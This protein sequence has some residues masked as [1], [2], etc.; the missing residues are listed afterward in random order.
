L[1]R[2]RERLQYYISL[3]EHREST[4]L[5][6]HY[7]SQKAGRRSPKVLALP[8][9]LFIKYALRPSTIWQASTDLQSKCFVY[10]EK[11]FQENKM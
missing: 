5:K 1:V 2:E 4:A 6:E 7:F 8:E 9:E 11:P 3:L 10:R